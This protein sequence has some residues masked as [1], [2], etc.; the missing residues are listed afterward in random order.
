[1]KKDIL[2]SYRVSCSKNSMMG[3]KMTTTVGKWFYGMPFGRKVMLIGA[4]LGM[5]GCFFPW[6]SFQSV[7]L[8]ALDHLKPFGYSIIF[9]LF[10]VVYL[11]LRE[12]FQKNSLFLGI[13]NIY[14]FFCFLLL[15]LYTIILE[16][17]VLYELLL[18]SPDSEVEWGVMISFIF[19]G[20]ALIGTFFSLSYTPIPS[21]ITAPLFPPRVSKEEIT[22]QP[23]KL[24]PHS[25]E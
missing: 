23:E 4:F 8:S 16:T 25:H 9:F 19:V 12:H 5:V 14:Y 3:E 6:F 18:Y 11:G 15:A 24:S 7:T 2:R 21:P 22:L 13:P 1:M 20:M 10:A 17:T